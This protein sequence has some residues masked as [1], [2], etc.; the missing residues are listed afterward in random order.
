MRVILA[1]P[2]AEEAVHA[3]RNHHDVVLGYQEPER[4][5]E[6]VRDRE[7]LIFR[8]GVDI[9][10]SVMEAAP[11]LQLLIRAGSGFDNIDLEHCRERG[12]RVVRVPG[13]SSQAVAEFTL[14]LVLAL[15]RRIVEA[16]AHLQRGRWP[17]HELGGHLISGKAMGVVGAGRIGRRVGEM[18]ALLGM[19]VLGCVEHPT[20]ERAEALAEKGI[21]MADFDTVVGQAE[22]LTVHT[23]LT[24]RTT[25]L[26]GD[27]E[28]DRMPPGG[29]LVNTARG[30]V[31]DESALARAL[32]AGTLAA[33]ALD[34][35]EKEGE[36]VLSPLA[37][38]PNVIL[39]PHIGGMAVESQEL[40]GRRAAQ[41]IDAYLEGRLDQECTAEERLI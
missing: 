8:S 38:R 7:A 28:L 19:R 3:L 14:G 10:A 18:G 22:V 31:V 6:L 11:G 24:P 1:S 12:I 16:D 41:V 37:G 30:G 27:A 5:R 13:P 2:I 4:L 29:I 39:S 40:I 34:V 36:G 25:G 23:P 21:T 35:H 33:A 26:I 32:D 15:S 9:S 20:T 17:K